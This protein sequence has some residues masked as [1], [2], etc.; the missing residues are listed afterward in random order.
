MVA[1]LVVFPPNLL[2]IYFQAATLQLSSL[3]APS[4]STD[5]RTTI[6]P[7]P[8]Y[9]SIVLVLDLMRDDPPLFHWFIFVPFAEEADTNIQQ[10]YKIN[11]I[12]NFSTGTKVYEFDRTTYTLATSMSVAAAAVIGRLPDQPG[13]T[14][15]DLVTL[16]SAIP[17]NVV[18]DVDKERE[19]K[20]TCRVW[21]REAVRLMNANGYV[22]CPDVNALEEEMWGYGRKAI[23]A[24][25]DGSFTKATLYTAAHCT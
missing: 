15:E 16:L 6:E 4:T 12:E 2:N 1:P 3:M 22:R 17:V 14:L 20:F 9:P 11:A 19:T 21:V 10:G 7:L 13:H 25:D 18:P 23:E 24:L 5:E 8:K